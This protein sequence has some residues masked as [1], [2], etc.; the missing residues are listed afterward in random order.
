MSDKITGNKSDNN[1]MR[2]IQTNR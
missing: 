2:K 1:Q